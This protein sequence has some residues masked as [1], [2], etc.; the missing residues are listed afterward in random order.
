[1]NILNDIITYIRRLIK[2]PSNAVITDNLIIDYINRFWL[3]DVDARIQLFDLKT[4][5]AFETIPGIDQYNMPMYTLQVEPGSQ[6][7]TSYPV[8]QQFLMPCYMNGIQ[9]PFYND[10]NA[11]FN[12]WPN[13]LQFIQP[14]ATGDG[15]T[16]TFQF[17]LPYF[18][19]LP[20]HLDITG[21]ID[22][23]NA[24]NSYVD[25]IFA[26]SFPLTSSGGIAIRTT[27]FYPQ[28]YLTYVSQN[29]N[30]VTVAD[31]GIFL[32]SSNNTNLY[33]L[34]MQVGAAPF[35]NLPLSSNTYSMTE[36]TVNYETG[37]VNVTF[38]SAPPAGVEI[39][40]QC[41]FYQQ[42]LPRAIL[43]YNNMFVLRPPPNTQYLVEL[44][45]YLTPA[46]FLS[47]SSAIPFGY[48]TEYIARGAARKILADTGDVEQFRF[49]EPLFLEQE[50]LVWKR[51]QRQFTAT[52]T[53]TVFSDLQGQS[54]Y[55]NIGQGS[56]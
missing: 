39:Q 11:F 33:G 6:N 21:V 25:P 32:E 2:S 3:L 26:N 20:G 14:V 31:S 9:V 23:V 24:G 30:N 49:Y 51:S 45:T 40:A 37:V 34:L 53:G 28:V 18:P 16:T 10:R 36:N 29:G 43:F 15:T 42:G 41:F 5:Y 44:D 12:L 47:T 55:N 22:Y 54:N 19:S 1:M 13:Y 27:S 52:R 35:G 8:Y 38:P 4:K 17:T 48:M 46:A 50:Q 7:I 56:T